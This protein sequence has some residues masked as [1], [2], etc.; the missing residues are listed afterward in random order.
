MQINLKANNINSLVFSTKIS[1]S[2]EL[3]EQIAKVSPPS[4]DGDN[5]FWDSYKNYRCVAWISK[6]DEKTSQSEIVFVYEP[7]G[8]GRLRKIDARVNQLTELLSPLGQFTFKCRVQFMFN[9]RLHVKSILHLP[10]KYLNI[11]N[12]PFDRIQGMHLVK[13]NGSEIKY[14]VYLEAP[15]EGVIGENILFNYTAPINVN[16]ANSIFNEAIT[17]SDKFIIRSEHA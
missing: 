4:E 17:I 9:K 5:D 14:E 8:W 12:M 6:A 3:K 1:L 2:P 13:L 16:L 11:P 10:D 7:G 15:A